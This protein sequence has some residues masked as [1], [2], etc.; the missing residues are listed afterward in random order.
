MNRETKLYLVSPHHTQTSMYGY[1]QPPESKPSTIR[2]V[3][4]PGVFIL[5]EEKNETYCY[6]Y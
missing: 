5:L 1:Y 3:P 6:T 4:N 2:R